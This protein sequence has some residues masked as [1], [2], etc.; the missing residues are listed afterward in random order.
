MYAVPR[1]VASLGLESPRGPLDLKSGGGG[2]DDDDDDDAT[3]LGL[4]KQLSL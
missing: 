1:T 2:D 3:K 4:V